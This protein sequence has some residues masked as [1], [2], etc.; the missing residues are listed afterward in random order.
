VTLTINNKI[1]ALSVEGFG[2][3]DDFLNQCDVEILKMPPRECPV[4][5][6]FTP[7]L[8]I[9]EIFM[10]K[11]TILTSL[12]HLTTHPYFIMQGEFS[13]WHRGIEVQRI[14]APY[15]GITEA[16]TRRLLYIHEDT[17]WTTCHV[18]DLTDPDEIIESITSNDFN[19]LVDKTNPRLNSWRYNRNQIKEKC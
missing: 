16:G 6:R 7:G 5:H 11:N 3:P 19:P 12:L 18:T 14:K 17:I 13:V 8:Y 15:T 4:T 1:D 9:R 2:D 10:P